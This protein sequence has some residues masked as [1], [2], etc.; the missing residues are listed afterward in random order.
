ML[1]AFI[2][3]KTYTNGKQN[4][5]IIINYVLNF[6]SNQMGEKMKKWTLDLKTN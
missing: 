5:F 6:K 2:N 4:T 1:L 3:I